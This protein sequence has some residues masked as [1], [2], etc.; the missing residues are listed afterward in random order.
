MRNILP[1]FFILLMPIIGMAGW[2]G[3]WPITT[4]NYLT[5]YKQAISD[6]LAAESERLLVYSTN[7]STGIYG[8]DTVY[9]SKFHF[10]EVQEL[11]YKTST[12][13]TNVGGLVVTNWYQAQTNYLTTNTITTS[14]NYISALN[15]WDDAFYYS[16][17]S[18]IWVDWTKEGAGWLTYFQTPQVSTS[19]SWSGSLWTA[20]V[21]TTF[22]TVFPKFTLESVLKTFPSDCYTNFY[23]Y[24]WVTNQTA[25]YGWQV[26]DY[27]HY[28]SGSTNRITVTSN[29]YWGILT[30]SK[31]NNSNVMLASA[32]YGTKPWKTILSYPVYPTSISFPENMP[33]AVTTNTDGCPA[34]G[35]F[36]FS[37]EPWAAYNTGTTNLY[38]TYTGSNGWKAIINYVGSGYGK[39]YWISQNPTINNWYPSYDP[40]NTREIW[41]FY[42]APTDDPDYGGRVYVYYYPIGYPSISYKLLG[43]RNVEM[44]SVAMIEEVG[45]NFRTTANP[46]IGQGIFYGYPGY[47]W[48]YYV[49]G[50]TSLL[51]ANNVRGRYVPN[52]LSTVTFSTFHISGREYKPSYTDSYGNV[53]P[54]E[55][56]ETMWASNTVILNTNWFHPTNIFVSISSFNNTNYNAIITNLGTEAYYTTTNEYSTM[57]DTVEFYYDFPGDLYDGTRDRATITYYGRFPTHDRGVKPLNGR[58][59]IAGQF[60]KFCSPGTRVKTQRD[61]VSWSNGSAP[62]TTDRWYTHAGWSNEITADYRM[63]WGGQSFTLTHGIS[64]YWTASPYTGGK[65][66]VSAGR[67]NSGASYYY[68][69]S[70]DTVYAEVQSYKWGI[71]G[72]HYGGSTATFYDQCYGF[73]YGI[74][75]STPVSVWLYG[76]EYGTNVFTLLQ[77][78]TSSGGESSGGLCYINSGYRVNG[79]NSESAITFVESTINDLSGH[80]GTI[81]AFGAWNWSGSSNRTSSLLG[82]YFPSSVI[83]LIDPMLEYGP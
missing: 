64:N 10:S 41:Y 47:S 35:D 1:I 30:S 24:T 45:W 13:S 49:W 17:N 46:T 36:S 18:G 39:Q 7:W 37:Y 75:V 4:N 52:R 40:P 29:L 68:E 70:N 79:N 72:S 22:P 76:K 50:D 65:L 21:S 8:Y 69:E 55:F 25:A 33:Y 5:T 62:W 71:N 66:T 43:Y 11:N 56:H 9:D 82:E 2:S 53:I 28:T 63:L 67:H 34:Y 80:I 38:P 83:G 20:N 54:S 61:T 14:K 15:K 16:L 19:W 12:I 57:G 6:L 32:Y 31:E 27:T 42:V 74:L 26:G 81:G 3:D 59:Y 60:A 58:K 73:A 77:G 48:D 44:E 78:E 51:N 23:L